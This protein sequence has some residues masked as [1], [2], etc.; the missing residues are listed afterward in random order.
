MSNQT[1]SEPNNL[2]NIAYFIIYYV[3]LEQ[4]FSDS[5]CFSFLNLNMHG[6][7]TNPKRRSIL[8]FILT[9]SAFEPS[10]TSGRSLSRFQ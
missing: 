3:N 10:G 2:R 6:V 7:M 1:K 9:K 8:P 5:F 4:T